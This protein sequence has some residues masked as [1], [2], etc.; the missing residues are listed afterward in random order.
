MTN[1]RE[2]CPLTV[3]VPAQGSPESYESGKPDAHHEL[4]HDLEGVV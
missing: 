4:S 2:G 3:V 1:A